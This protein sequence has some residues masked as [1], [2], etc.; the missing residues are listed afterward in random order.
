M[1]SG[2]YQHFEALL[3]EQITDT[4][5]QDPRWKGQYKYHWTL[6][7]C[8]SK[9][10]FNNCILKS[11]SRNLQNFDQIFATGDI[12]LEKNAAW[13][14]FWTGFERSLIQRV[15]GLPWDNTPIYWDSCSSIKHYKIN[16]PK[17]TLFSYFGQIDSIVPYPYLKIKGWIRSNDLIAPI[18]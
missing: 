13:I 3:I 17:I 18:K 15:A 6:K 10:N 5:V 16:I 2:K 4:Q 7:R 11:S 8:S 12:E 1:G 9:T 14:V